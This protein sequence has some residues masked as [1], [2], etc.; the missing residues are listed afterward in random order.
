MVF[1][2]LISSLGHVPDG[3]PQ[4]L[5]V[6]LPCLEEQGTGLAQVFA[7]AINTGISHDAS[8]QIG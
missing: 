8:D 1:Y 7:S 5:R 3:K 4:M 6:A 2:Q